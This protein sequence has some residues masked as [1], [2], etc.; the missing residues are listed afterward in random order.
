MHKQTPKLEWRFT[1][2]DAEWAGQQ[3]LLL[4]EVTAG[5]SRRLRLKQYLGLVMT[6]LLFFTSVGGWWRYSTQAKLHA[7]EAELRAA[8]AQKTLAVVTP[9]ADALITTIK[10]KR[11][12]SAWQLHDG[13]WAA[14]DWEYSALPAA[15]QSN[16]P[17][18]PLDA[19]VQ[20]MELLGDQAI[21]NVI[22][23]DQRGQPAYRQTRF[24]RRISNGGWLPVP[25]DATL[26]GPAR[27]LQTPYFVY[28][29]RQRDAAVVQAVAP[30]IDALYTRM[31]GNFGLSLIPMPEKLVIVVRVTQAPGRAAVF[32]A[33]QQ[34]SVASPAVYLAPVELT[35]SELLAQAIA[36]LLIEQVLTQAS[37]Q[38]AVGDLWR[39]LLNGLRLWQMWELDLPLAVWREAVVT[40]V[41]NDLP[42]SRPGQ[43]VV[44]P[45]RY[46]ALCAAHKL[47]LLS[48]TE[49]KIPL[50]CGEL[51][52]ED[53]VLSPW[54]WYDPLTHLDQLGAP[55]HPE[56][57]QGEPV[58]LRRT[59]QPS[60]TVTLATVIEYAMDTYGRERLPALM[61]GLRQYDRWETLIPAVYGVSA[62]KFEAGWQTYL[63]EH[64]GVAEE[65][66]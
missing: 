10:D 50:L 3:A 17:T 35:N 60:D 15:S 46:T 16:A 53:S 36:L 28:H 30:Q 32:D 31:W 8:V 57:F 61:A 65:H 54:G 19:V 22:L 2:S 7:A 12:S 43:T 18:V 14:F 13:T 55:L 5:L 58:S 66:P 40:W 52:W 23:N 44:L 38:E 27:T 4:P 25:P 26:W 49:L 56:E 51:A 34:I 6:T 9:N 29:F 62:A 64:Y 47:W 1:E 37:E 11:T 24:Y 41:Y 33:A 63:T 59:P 42:A 39:P 45:A 21:A 48:P 20:T